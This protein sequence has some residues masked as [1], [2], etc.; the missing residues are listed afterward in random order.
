MKHSS[1]SLADKYAVEVDQLYLTGTQALVRL[2]LLQRAADQRAGLNTAC[3]ISGYRGS[4][5][6]GLDIQLWQARTALQAQHIHF[7]P[8]VNEDTALNAVWG[9]Q[10]VGLHPGA[11]YDG[12]FALWYGKGPG[13]DRSGDVMKHANLA[14]TAAH[15]GVLLVAGDDHACKSSSVPHQS[16]PAFI[17][18][19]VPVLAPANV[20]DILRLGLHGWA[21]SRYSGLYVGFK[22]VADVI[23]SSASLQFDLAALHIAYPDGMMQPPGGHGIRLPDNPLDQEARINAVG[24]PAVL[25]YA[26]ANRLARVIGPAPAA[27]IGIVTAG[28]S[29]LDVRQALADLGLAESDAVRVLKLALTWPVEPEIVRQFAAGLETILVVEEKQSLIERQVKDILYH[30]P[31]RPAVLGKHDATG[32]SLLR[33]NGELYAGDIVRALAPLLRPLLGAETIDAR[34]GFLDAQAA[35]LRGLDIGA[36]RTAYFCSGCPHNTSTK[37]VDGSRALAG[38][39][40]HYMASFMDRRTD[41]VSQMGGEG[42]GWIGQAPFTE[43]AHVFANLG[44]GTY[45]HSGIMAIR[46]AIASGV[47]ITY[48]ILF[49]DAVAMTGGQPVDGPLDVPMITR[50]L[51][52]EGMGRIVIVTDE[53][54]KYAAVTDL[55]PGVTVRHR[56]DLAEVE[57]TL[58]AIA[59]AT[60]LIYDQTCASE[61]RRRRKRGT[62]ADPA[63]RVIINERVCEG[64]GDCSAASNCLSV[65]PLAT[66]YGEKRAI[67]QSS[68]NKDFSCVEGFCPS[69]VTVHGGSLRKG[70]GSTGETEVALPEPVLPALDTPFNL[71]IAGVGGTGVVTIGALLGVAAH[72]EGKHVTVLDQLGMAQ[73]GGSVWSHI[74]IAARPEALQALRIGPGDADLLLACDLVVGAGHEALTTLRPGGSR[75]VVNTHETI[76]ADFLLHPAARIPATALRHA[77]ADAVGEGRC[78]TIDATTLATA[79]LGDA[80][81]ANLFLLGY[82]WQRGLIPLG[83]EALM[84]A[85]ELNGTAVAMNQAAFRWGRLAAVDPARVE[86][87]AQA[88]R[89]AP[90]AAPGD[91]ASLI[92]R[93]AADLTLYQNRAYAS[94]YRAL[95][96]QVGAREAA[97]L[98]GSTALA[99]AVARNYYK[100]LAYKDEYEVARLYAR[101]EFKASLAARFEGDFKLQFHLA[102]PLLA[103]RDP[104]TGH[105]RKQAFGGWMLPAFGVLRHFKWLRGTRLDPFGRSEERQAERALIVQYEQTMADLLAA[106]TPENVAIAV[107]IGSVPQEIAGFGHVKE[108]R[109]RAAAARHASLL[110]QF[111]APVRAMAAE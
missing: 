76:T 42:A 100:L 53:P 31:D 67:E 10:Q 70:G 60:A 1:L 105:L 28:K 51:A 63:K 26:R 92:E 89:P 29:T 111:R 83:F 11:K 4:P 2:P 93:R 18:A 78:E 33:A 62:L 56:R 64:C 84:Q 47:N 91:L 79:L 43:E 14:G 74:K 106:L 32:A 50:Q 57:R 87:A 81:G 69:F 94:R 34:L 85:I 110:A 88:G 27:R 6:G 48:K 101:P 54:E 19:L 17:A 68:C 24:L 65:V 40:C 3:F 73:K 36:Q 52:A 80:I 7:Q 102:P 61:K 82:A 25:A 58:R 21:L 9:S 20:E 23:D 39:G 46:A 49:N 15:G 98:P 96:E 86:A 107:Q 103:K 5:L 71:L 37:L 45:F 55:A 16:E 90:E 22:T 108:R 104:R 72:A 12:V 30:A 99:E 8:G 75:A 13:V 66:E 38:I 77:L 109:M 95:V 44:D 41:S 59:G 97:V 35:T